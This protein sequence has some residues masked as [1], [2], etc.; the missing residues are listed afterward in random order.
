MYGGSLDRRLPI[1]EQVGFKNYAM[2]GAQTKP[3]PGLALILPLT[4]SLALT[5]T[6]TPTLTLAA[7]LR[8][9]RNR[10]AQSCPTYISLLKHPT[11]G[12]GAADSEIFSEPSL[13]EEELK[14]KSS[15]RNL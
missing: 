11:L 13:H 12:S 9:A 15:P 1:H 14:T 8:V 2:C 7:T 6:L 4:V 3:T 10:Q 5:L